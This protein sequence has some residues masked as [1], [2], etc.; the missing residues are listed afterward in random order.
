[1]R[2][3]E[4]ATSSRGLGVSMNPRVPARTV[5]VL[6]LLIIS[7]TESIVMSK[8][9]VAF[10]GMRGGD[11]A[12]PNAYSGAQMSSA[13]SPTRICWSASSQPGTCHAGSRDV[14]S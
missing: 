13:R 4:R 14:C 2:A 1:M 8:R 5:S 3:C 11:P 12:S 9:T 10:A 7:R 6:L